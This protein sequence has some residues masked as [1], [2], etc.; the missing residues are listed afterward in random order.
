M[1]EGK[2]MDL[3][4]LLQGERGKGTEA[5]I[6]GISRSVCRG[7]W[8]A[9]ELED[10]ACMRCIDLVICHGLPRTPHFCV[11]WHLL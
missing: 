9:N 4:G 8:Y 7:L 11:P 10:T 1:G 5:K 3:L 2:G 6:Q